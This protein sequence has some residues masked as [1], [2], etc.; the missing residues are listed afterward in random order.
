MILSWAP[1]TVYLVFL[2]STGSIRFGIWAVPLFWVVGLAILLAG[3]DFDA[4]V[5]AVEAMSD[6]FGA[7]EGLKYVRLV[8]ASEGCSGGNEMIRDCSGWPGMRRS[9]RCTSTSRGFGISAGSN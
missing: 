4:G 8:Q 6:G 9:S 7:I 1:P 5:A 3:V 2:E